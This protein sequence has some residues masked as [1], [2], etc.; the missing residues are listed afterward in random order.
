MTIAEVPPRGSQGI[1]EEQFSQANKQYEEKKT[2]EAI[3]TGSLRYPIENQDRYQAYIKFRL[4]EIVPPTFGEATQSALSK[5]IDASVSTVRS[6]AEQS[7]GNI[8]SFFNNLGGAAVDA[9][10]DL[11]SGDDDNTDASSV[12]A[13]DPTSGSIVTTREVVSK[14]DNIVLYLPTALTFNDGL[15]YDT[16]ALGLA[17]GATFEAIA[18]GGG[19]LNALGEVM[20]QG[21]KTISELTGQAK[22][23]DIARVAMVRGMS[24]IPG[25]GAL[26]EGASIAVGVTVN[27]NVRSSFKGVTIREFTFQFKFIPK[28]PEESKVVEDII[29][30]FRYAAYPETIGASGSLSLD[31]TDDA[32]EAGLSAGYKYPDLFDIEVNYKTE[33]GDVRVGN[34]FQKCFLKGVS[35]NYNPSTMAFH[36]DGKPVEIDLTLNFQE[37]KTLDRRNIAQG[38]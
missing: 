11:F 32:V 5:G 17:G 30:R 2:E 7:N 3:L 26:A 24:A 37:E 34:K 35:T 38:Y 29:K 1:T 10:I 20:K 22:G 16:P 33:S 27:P 15:Q 13:N 4:S 21:G 18:K 8:F 6:S 25:A 28:S 12:D 23:S 36:K 31:G 19:A 9:V 14:G